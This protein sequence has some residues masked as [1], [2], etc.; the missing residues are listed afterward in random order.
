MRT[1]SQW[2]RFAT[3]MWSS[4]SITA[5]IAPGRSP[6][7]SRAK[8][9]DA[10]AAD[11][12]CLSAEALDAVDPAAASSEESELHLHDAVR[13][14]VFAAIRG[15]DR[16]R[17]NNILANVMGQHN[18]R[19]LRVAETEKYAHVTYFFNGGVE[20]PF[21]GEDRV[22]VQSPKV[23]TYD[24]TPEMSA[25]GVADAVVKA[26]EDGTF[27]VMVVNFANAD[28]VGHSGKIRADDQGRRDRGLLPGTDLRGTEAMRR[29]DDRH[30]RPW[31]CRADDRSGNGRSAHGAHTTILSR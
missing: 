29:S 12:I 31:Q 21:P 25:A 7:S 17:L 1:A 27:D 26:I 22:M 15:S 19:N 28:M 14:E 30:S 23:A 2:G 4:T 11:A 9:T 8:R 13:P 10:A 5:P 20:K 3:R 18:L 16:S 6:A 24:L